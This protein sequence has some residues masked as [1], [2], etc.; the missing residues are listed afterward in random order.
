M[1]VSRSVVPDFATS[2]TVACQIPLLM[3]FSRQEYG[4]GYPF[5]SPGDLPDAEIESE[6]PTLQ[7]DSLPSEPLGSPKIYILLYLK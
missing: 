6:S 1:C 2:W 4:S 7:R 5:P 3:E